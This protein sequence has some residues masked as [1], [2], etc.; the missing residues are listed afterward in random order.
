MDTPTDCGFCLTIVGAYSGYRINSIAQDLLDNNK[1]IKSS[2][3]QYNPIPLI[4]SVVQEKKFQFNKIKELKINFI[5]EQQ[6]H[7]N[8]QVS[9]DHFQRLLSNMAQILLDSSQV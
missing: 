1:Q 2:T 6:I 5:K 4:E 8:I 7:F 3:Q 9:K